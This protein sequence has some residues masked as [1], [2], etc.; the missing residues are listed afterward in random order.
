[1][2][3]SVYV[4]ICKYILLVRRN[5]FYFYF[6]TFLY[7][8]YVYSLLYIVFTLLVSLSAHRRFLK[9]S[10]YNEILNVSSLNLYTVAFTKKK[11]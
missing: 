2:H 3:V 7:F 1:M 10:K 9:K 4:Y 6:I 11:A 8:F 5:F